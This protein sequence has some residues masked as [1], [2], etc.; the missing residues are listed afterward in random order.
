MNDDIK[1][2]TDRAIPMS[3]YTDDDT[4]MTATSYITNS[5]DDF[6]DDEE[7]LEFEETNFD[8]ST[9]TVIDKKTYRNQEAFLTAYAEVGVISQALKLC[10]VSQRC[11]EQ[12]WNH[13]KFGYKARRRR[14]E[15]SH[16][17]LL[18]QKLFSLIGQLT[19]NNSVVGLL[20]ALNAHRSE[21]TS[22]RY[23]PSVA[24]VDDTAKEVMS[25]LRRVFSLK[26]ESLRLE[27]GSDEQ[28][29][30]PEQSEPEAT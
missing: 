26:R 28:V 9:A 25:E 24:S 20:A 2:T 1:P 8:K 4:V 13:D 19:P 21:K 7:Q 22:E 14:A 3:N 23:R 6:I 15:E 27:P 30:Q 29:S 11:Q 5:T 12:W 16:A 10:G 17:D 18:E